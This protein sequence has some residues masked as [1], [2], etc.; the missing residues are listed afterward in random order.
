M[1]GF[2]QFWV[3]LR[4]QGITNQK[5]DVTLIGHIGHFACRFKYFFCTLSFRRFKFVDLLS[6]QGMGWRMRMKTA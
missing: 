2:G 4:D 3:I 1:I 5:P 6:N